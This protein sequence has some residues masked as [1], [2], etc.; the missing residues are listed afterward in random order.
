VPDP[1]RLLVLDA[2]A[3]E[4][5]AELR[6]GGAT[7]AGALYAAMLARLAPGARVDVLCP[8]DADADLPQGV[9]LASYDGAAWT[10]SNLSLS[11][12]DDPPVRRQLELA[13]ALGASGVASFGSCFAVQIAA[14]AGGGAVAP[15]PRG[16]EFGLARK[17]TLSAEGRAH[18]MFR[19][20]PAAFDAL[21]SHGDEVARVPAGGTLLA[22]NGFTRV[23]SLDAEVAGAPFW[24]VQYHPE[25]D[26]REVAALCRV[27]APALVAQGTFADL[28]A[29]RAWACEAEALQRDAAR[30]DLAWRLGVDADVLDPAERECEVRNWLELCVA[31]RARR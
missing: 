7:E 12:P 31:P 5:R 15:N 18:P 1:L 28:E 19:G 10:G 27:R 14:V 11:R 8:A 4:G 13:R 22:S 6:A 30:G 23:Q 2:Y 29:A 21:T 25:Y 16:R 9:A 20:R 24:A 17:I 3:R 26:L